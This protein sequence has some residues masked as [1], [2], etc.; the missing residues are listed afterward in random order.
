MIANKTVPVVNI[1]PEGKICTRI[2]FYIS[3]NR[4]TKNMST[5][6]EIVCKYSTS[7]GVAR[8]LRKKSAKKKKK[9]FIL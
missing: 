3:I 7:S 5:Y 2:H 9:A 1:G 4:T 8:S 6:E